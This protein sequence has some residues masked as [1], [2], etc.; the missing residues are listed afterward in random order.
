MAGRSR[1]INRSLIILSALIVARA[2]AERRPDRMGMLA[3]LT[4]VA[5]ATV[6]VGWAFATRRKR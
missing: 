4:V 3:T 5:L 6:L 1:W 2:V